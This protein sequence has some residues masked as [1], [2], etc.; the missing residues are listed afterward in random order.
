MDN[1]KFILINFAKDYQNML[2]VFRRWAVVAVV[3]QLAIVASGCGQKLEPFDVDDAHTS[4]RTKPPNSTDT[5]DSGAISTGSDN[6]M[7]ATDSVK[8]DSCSEDTTADSDIIDT[9]TESL[10]VDSETA[11]DAT[12][13]ESE[14]ETVDLDSETTAVDSETADDTVD[15]DSET[16]A[17]D[18]ETASDTID[19]ESESDTVDL[20][21]ETAAVDSETASDT[22]DSD[23]S[24]EPL[25]SETILGTP[26]TETPD[27]LELCSR[28]DLTYYE[29]KKLDN[30]YWWKST[31]FNPVEATINGFWD[32]DR[33]EPCEP[34]ESCA[35]KADYT[36]DDGIQVLV[37]KLSEDEI[38][39][40]LST[41][42]TA[43]GWFYIHYMYTYTYGSGSDEFGEYWS[44]LTISAEWEG[45]PFS[46]LP[47]DSHVSTFRYIEYA[48]TIIAQYSFESDG[49]EIDSR[50]MRFSG[51]ETWEMHHQGCI[52]RREDVDQQGK[53][54]LNGKCFAVHPEDPPYSTDW[55]PSDDC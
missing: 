20:D 18:S 40:T 26:L 29:A 5:S 16:L 45:R 9:G 51:T 39:I 46:H 7:S 36:S 8:A 11:S 42:E 22:D 52:W 3:T 54:K 53:L 43:L 55:I 23:T 33:L 25:W 10:A 6:G 31:V 34:E 24:T 48:A 14:S 49:C 1:L 4:N 41:N 47:P 32:S 38:E 13:T 37:E 50:L 15:L 12:D 30:F 28:S 2:V 19:T 35:E 17:V 27:M 44:V 21:S